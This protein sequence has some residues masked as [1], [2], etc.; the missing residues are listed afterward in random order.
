MLSFSEVHFRK[1]SRRFRIFAQIQ[2]QIQLFRMTTGNR[3]VDG[4]I[5][6]WPFIMN[7]FKQTRDIGIV[8]FEFSKRNHA[9]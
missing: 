2:A 1:R 7:V 8:K 3:W 5:D 6:G 4:W 9:G